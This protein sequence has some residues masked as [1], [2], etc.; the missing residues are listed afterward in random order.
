MFHGANPESLLHGVI[1]HDAMK[2]HFDDVLPFLNDPLINELLGELLLYGW[3]L[4]FQDALLL[5][6]VYD[7]LHELM[8]HDDDDVLV[9]YAL[10]IGLFQMAFQPSQI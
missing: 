9:L 10:L 1:Y 5:S 8:L 4:I 3:I 7:H 6:R 2:H